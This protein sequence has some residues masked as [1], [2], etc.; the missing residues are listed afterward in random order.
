MDS[1]V[2]DNGLLLYRKT[3]TTAAEK[4]LTWFDRAGRLLGQ[5]GTKANY[6]NVELSPNGDRVAVD[7]LTDNNRDVWMIDLARGVPSR[8]TFDPASD[9]TPVWSPDGNS[10]AF[11]STRNGTHIYQKS[12]SGVGSDTLM[13]KSAATEIPVSWS[14]DGRYIVF[15]RQKPA[16]VV[17][18]RHLAAGAD[19]RTEGV[20]VHRFAVRQSAGEDFAGRPLDRVHDERLGDVPDRRS[21][22]SGSRTAASGRSRHREAS[23][24]NGVVMEASSTI[25]PSTET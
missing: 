7:I 23:S 9:W 8:I 1:T 25:W 21:V 15:S 10:I 18:S 5:V 13:F 12:A 2:S 11:A 3:S 24:P 14:H 4:Q 22:V 6:G 17:R 16:G 19:R 20:S